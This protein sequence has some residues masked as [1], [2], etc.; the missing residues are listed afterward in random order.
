MFTAK[1]AAQGKKSNKAVAKAT[2]KHTK[3]VGGKKTD[4]SPGHTA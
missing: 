1:H 3:K 2:A 4:T